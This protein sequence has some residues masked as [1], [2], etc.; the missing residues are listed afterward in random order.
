M[1][2]QMSGKFIRGISGGIRRERD[3]E[4]NFGDYDCI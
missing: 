4:R 3:Y 1:D 2:E